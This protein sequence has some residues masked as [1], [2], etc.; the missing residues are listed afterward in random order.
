MGPTMLAFVERLRA[1]FEGGAV[2]AVVGV[3]EPRGEITLD[4]HAS[5]WLDAARALRDEFGF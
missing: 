4:V 3:A 5:G 2:A 1:R